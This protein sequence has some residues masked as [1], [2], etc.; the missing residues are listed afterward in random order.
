VAFSWTQ[1]DGMV[2]LGTLGGTDDDFSSA[3]AVN[4]SGQVVGRSTTTEYV[5][6]TID[7]RVAE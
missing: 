4:R 3:S 6:V 1:Q 7:R 2:D 5:N